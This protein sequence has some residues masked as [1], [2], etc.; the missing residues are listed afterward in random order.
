M[1]GPGVSV[2]V[3]VRVG[4]PS[5]PPPVIVAPAPVV[6]APAPPVTM[7][8][9][10]PDYYVWDGVEFVG[11]IG[12]TYYYLGPGDVWL[13]MDA[14]RLARFHTWESMHADWRTHATV[15]V[16]YRTDAHGHAVPI[17]GGNSSDKIES[18]G[19]E[20]IHGNGNGHGH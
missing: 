14:P 7:E 4:A 5:P 17:R 15:N 9:G 10:V 3:G 19:N 16:K 1:A 11:V 13:V 18:H 20:G 2:G 12:P 8:V 6:V